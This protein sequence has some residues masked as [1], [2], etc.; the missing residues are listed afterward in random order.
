VPVKNMGAAEAEMNV[1]LRAQRVLAV[2][3]EF[4]P[5]GSI[6]RFG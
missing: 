1:F 2:K 6:E 3:K 5:D 4:V